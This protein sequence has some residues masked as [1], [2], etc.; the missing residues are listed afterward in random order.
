MAIERI[1]YGG[2]GGEL[3]P[4]LARI[5]ERHSGIRPEV[6]AAVRQIIEAVRQ[7]GDEALVEFSREFDGADM[8]TDALRVPASDLAAA[9][10]SLEED[11]R[12]AIEEAADN[13]R[14]FHERQR[15]NSWFVEDGDGVILGKKITPIRRVG[16]CVPG[17]QA[18]LISSLLMAAVPAQVAGVAEICAVAPPGPDGLPH[19]AILAAADLLEVEEVYAVGGAQAVAALAYGTETI[20]AVDKIVGPGGPYTVAAKQL[21]FGR[22]GIE[23]IP[24]PSE[25]VVVAD[26]GADPRY[27]AA[28][29]LSQAEH[30]SG[31]EAAVCITPSAE[32]AGE[33]QAEVARQLQSLPRGEIA[34]EALASYGAVIEV[35]DLETGLELANRIAPEHVELLVDEPWSWLGAI[36]NAG[37]VFLGPAST[38]PVGDYFAGTN[39]VLPTNG[40]AR[41]ASSLGL[42]DFVK[43]TSVVSYTAERLA[44]TGGRIMALAR[45]ESMEAHAR[46]VQVRLDD[47][48][49]GR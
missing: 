10:R 45:A 24:G 38:E 2:A 25:I 15:A 42:A 26:E 49:N 4:L 14:A 22:V 28:D 23:S 6:E 19:A 13:I 3:P 33:V 35:P 11:L 27:I 46:A 37:A 7:R 48:G 21:V 29:L 30:G 12:D 17:G 20:A 31:Y 18:P 1:A 32:Q 8:A 44:R 47:Y 43:T 40:A 34:A 16:I 39:H 41:F 36:D 5:L 9:A